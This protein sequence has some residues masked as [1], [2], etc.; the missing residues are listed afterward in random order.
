MA[1]TE[2]VGHAERLGPHV[3]DRPEVT[4]HGTPVL[5]P[6]ATPPAL[7]PQAFRLSGTLGDDEE[8]LDDDIELLVAEELLADDVELLDVEE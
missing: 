2:L 8:L 6:M 4:Q 5:Q 7:K 3:S 1:V